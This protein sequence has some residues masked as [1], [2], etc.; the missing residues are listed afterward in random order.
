MSKSMDWFATFALRALVAVVPRRFLSSLSWH[1]DQYIERWRQNSVDLRRNT[2]FERLLLDAAGNPWRFLLCGVGVWGAVALLPLGL[3]F[4]GVCLPPSAWT[5]S[6][7][8][9]YFGTAWSVQ[10]TV[11][12]LVYPLV[13]SFV[14]LLL[15]R[16]A[17]VKVALT[18]YLLETAVIP[19]GASSFALLVLMTIEYLALSWLTIEQVQAMMVANMVWLAVNLLLTGWFLART[20]KYLQDERRV[21]ALLWL[22]Q[23]VT[24][25]QDVRAYVTGLFLQNAQTQGWLPGADFADEGPGPKV[26]VYPMGEGRPVVQVHFSAPM[27]LRDVHFKPVAWAVGRWAKRIEKTP[28]ANPLLELPS[29]PAQPLVTHVLCRVREA[30]EPST[31]GKAAIRVSYKFAKASQSVMPFST[32]EVMEE[33]GQEAAAQIDQGR[34]PGFRQALSDLVDVHT[35]LLKAAQFRSPEG[36][37]DNVSVLQDPYGFGSR[38]M[39]REWMEPYRAIVE[40]A[41]SKLE[42]DSRYFGRAAAISGRLVHHVGEQ[43]HH[44]LVDLMLASTLLMYHVGLWWTRHASRQSVPAVG[45]SQLL[46][47][48]FQKIY[49]DALQ[50]W[51]G[52]WE[53]I[54][55]S[56]D[57]DAVRQ[58]S[59]VWDANVTRVKV[60]A[61][62]VDETV[63]LL[64]IAVARGDAEASRRLEDSLVKWWGNRQYEFGAERGAPRPQWKLLNLTLA[65]LSWQE[66]QAQIP[67]LPEG[68]EAAGVAG[69]LLAIALKRYWTDVCMVA[70]VVLLE[71]AADT[72]DVEPSLAVEIASALMAGHGYD[73]G[74]RVEAEPVQGA[75]GG[76]TRLARAQFASRPYSLRLDT[77]VERFRSDVRAPM[78]SGRMYSFSGAEDVD[79]LKRG[80]GMY[81][82]ACAAGQHADLRGYTQLVDAWRADLR[83]LDRTA[84]HFAALAETIRDAAFSKQS[85]VIERVRAV[86]ARAEPVADAIEQAA[87]TCDEAV[88]LAST[89]HEKTVNDAPLDPDRLLELAQCVHARVLSSD[90]GTD[91]PVSLTTRFQASDAALEKSQQVFTGVSKLPYTNPPLESLDDG[92]TRWFAQYVGQRVFAVA[93]ARL[94]KKHG[95]EPVRDDHAEAFFDDLL[96]RID[97]VTAEGGT[98]VVLVAAGGRVDRLSPYRL[99]EDGDVPK[100]VV[101][102]PPPADEGGLYAT[103]NEVAVYSVPMDRRRVLVL[104]KEWL[105]T[106]RFLSHPGGLGFAVTAT[107]EVAGKIDLTFE[108]ACEFDSP[109]V[110]Q[111]GPATIPPLRSR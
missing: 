11:V 38:P 90:G 72:P 97:N 7:L 67:D 37:L 81:M 60:Y 2:W 58:G 21:Q 73:S 82:A 86:L 104:P 34:E 31:F 44:V 79:T 15:Q 108:F 52:A 28:G 65:E 8:P 24:L 85:P 16:R 100:G 89:A 32:V 48:P 53:S 84:R 1:V 103:V 49:S 59:D 26:M 20:A 42:E 23:C 102:R 80:Q 19:A 55:V 25:P 95:I 14:T 71:H 68:E 99:P 109:G 96:M 46:A 87:S 33:L 74:G 105:S 66:A 4:L 76:L 88:T 35:G 77:I 83:L 10:A 93:L 78:T 75:G 30:E 50:T 17:T 40:A 41:V 5:R 13:V 107:A 101:I 18:A 54:H 111:P 91:F 45:T 57:N 64:L 106:L 6:D 70:A 63:R 51:V 56:V 61:Q 62:H 94:Q 43:P 22:T 47:P 39:N 29:T 9:T 3:R 12:A 36:P 69:K 92:N 110:S 27:E 98:P